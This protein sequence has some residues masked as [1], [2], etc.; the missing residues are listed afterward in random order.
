[1]KSRKCILSLLLLVVAMMAAIQFSCKKEEEVETVE[2]VSVRKYT[3]TVSIT[4]N[5]ST[6]LYLVNGS[7]VIGKVEAGKTITTTVESEESYVILYLRDNSGNSF[8][9]KVLQNE[10]PYS[11]VVPAEKKD[12]TESKEEEKKEEEKKEETKKEEETTKEEETWTAN[13]EVTNNSWLP[14]YLYVSSYGSRPYATINAGEVYNGSLSVTGKSNNITVYLKYIGDTQKY[15][16]QSLSSVANTYKQT[17]AWCLY[18]MVTN[19]KSETVYLMSSDSSD[20][21]ATIKS[22]GTAMGRLFYF[23]ESKT[24]VELYVKNAKGAVLE[25]K[26]YKIKQ[27]SLCSIIVNTDCYYNNTATLKITNKE[28]DPYTIYIN[29]VSKGKLASGKTASFTITANTSYTLKAV[30]ASGYILWATE[31][32][33]TKKVSCCETGS[34]SF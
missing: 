22:S 15:E 26:E 10:E 29:G 5:G 14:M 27:D 24:S 3:H 20:P 1:M 25:S 34:W 16:E 8:Y 33:N 23:D 21:I 19:R 13:F 2:E 17:I 32:S 30:Q 4:N 28:D 6:T 18:Y 12:N 11:I 9:K 31:Y 7:D